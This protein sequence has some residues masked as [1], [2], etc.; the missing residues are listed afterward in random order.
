MSRIP[1]SR[2]AGRIGLSFL[3]WMIAFAVITSAFGVTYAS[4]KNR[5][6]AVKTEIDKLDREIAICRMSANQYRAKINA[7]SNRWAM[8]S[9]LVSNNSALR[10][11]T[12]SQLEFARS[13]Q[14]LAHITAN[15]QH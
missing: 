11:I 4:L 3:M 6:V 2:Y 8:R 15:T 1:S 12:R 14:E 9:R 7:Q 13:E 5:Q 10:P